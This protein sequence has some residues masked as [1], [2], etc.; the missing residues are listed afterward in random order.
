MTLTRDSVN[1]LLSGTTLGTVTEALTYTSLG[2]VATATASVGG[3]SVLTESYTRDSLGRISTKTET[4]QG[5]TTTYGYT[6]DT[7]GRL[8]EVTHNGNTI[9]TYAYDSNGNRLSKTAPGGTFTGS[10]DAQDRL[11]TYNGTTYAYTA[12]GELLSKTNTQHPA[13]ST[14][15]YDALGNLRSVTLP[16]GTA[17]S[18]VM[19][20]ENRRIGK[21]V[22][23]SLVQ[24]FLYENQL[25]P[26]AELDGSGNLV[27]RFVYCGC[28]A[29]NIPQYLLKGGVTYR[30]I[31][32]HLGSPRLIIDSTTGAIVQRMDYDE[33]GNVILDTN[34]GFQPFGFAGGIYDRDTGLTRHGARDYDPETGRWTSKDPIKFKGIDTNLYGYVLNN[35]LRFIDPDGLVPRDRRYGLPDDFWE[36]VE[37]EKDKRGRAANDNLEGEELWEW[38]EEWQQFKT[39]KKPTRIKPP[40]KR[41][42]GSIPIIIFRSIIC[43][44]DPTSPGCEEYCGTSGSPCT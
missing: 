17:I 11:L 34:P 21:T 25:E 40:H 10:Y 28:G 27:S 5:T 20:G 14:Y 4:I 15:S 32:D 37:R 3:S 2:D 36:W 39:K 8:T 7:A 38:H 9:A 13:P 43:I 30:I 6:Y 16:T 35:P 44:F 41:F 33:F 18:Y 24:G 26:V 22:N 29:G 31:S 19:D 23:G 1:G 42:P 12:N